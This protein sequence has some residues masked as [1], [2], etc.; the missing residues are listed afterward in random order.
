MKTK[1]ADYLVYDKAT[2][3]YREDPEQAVRD[4][5]EKHYDREVVRKFGTFEEYYS[6]IEGNTECADFTDLLILSNTM[7]KLLP[8]L[9]QNVVHKLEEV[10]FLQENTAQFD[11]YHKK[12]LINPQKQNKLLLL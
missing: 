9:A 11:D 1:A 4:V 12:E 3:K 7:G 5:V 10:V 2:G 8:F 6:Y